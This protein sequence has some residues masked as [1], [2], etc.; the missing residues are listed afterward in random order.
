M[1]KEVTINKIKEYLTTRPEVACAYLFGSFG[2][3]DFVEGISDIDIA[4]LPKESKD[5]I[6]DTTQLQ[7][8]LENIL[9]CNVDICDMMYLK[10]EILYDVYLRENCIYGEYSDE[11]LIAL[12]A[13]EDYLRNN[14]IFECYMKSFEYY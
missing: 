11:R 10:K 5:L 2:T 4:I 12:D 14:P 1:D 9:D 8:D 7:L 13:F 6:F 3:E